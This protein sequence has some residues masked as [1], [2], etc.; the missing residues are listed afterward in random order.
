MEEE[1]NSKVVYVFDSIKDKDALKQFE[2][3]IQDQADN[4]A[5]EI[6]AENEP[7]VIYSFKAYRDMYELQDVQLSKNRMQALTDFEI[8]LRNA[9]KYSPDNMSKEVFMKITEI[10]EFFCEVKTEYN[11]WD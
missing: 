4:Y 3:Y 9:Y 6:E 11:L 2:A 10:W 5:N 1:T 7:T 8:W